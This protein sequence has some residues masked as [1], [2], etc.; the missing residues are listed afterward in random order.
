MKNSS[1]PYTLGVWCTASAYIMWGFL[2]LYWKLLDQIPAMEILA[3]RILWSLVFVT[4]ALLLLVKKDVIWTEMKSLFSSKKSFLV[5]LS[6]SLLISAN[7]VIYIWAVN[8]DHIIEASLGYYMNPLISVLLGVI[9]LKEKLSNWQIISFILAAIGVMILTVHFGKFPWV[10]ISLALSFAVYGLLKKIVSFSALLSLA[11]ETLFVT[12]IAL[13][14]ILMLQ[15]EGQGAL[16][17]ISLST[18][19]LLIGAGIATAFPLYLFAQGAKSIPLSMIGFLQYIAPSISLMIGVLLY[20]EPFTMIHM[21]TFFFIWTA[22]AI[23]SIA[24]TKP[25]IDLDARLFKKKT[26]GA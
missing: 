18:T 11:F 7:W 1:N 13:I 14:Y 20:K 21:I 23:F 15:F 26:L 12:P 5:M 6:A 24:K 16:G 22:L 3:H 25:M 10:S 4:I 17:T 19:L 2:P 9:I 8:S